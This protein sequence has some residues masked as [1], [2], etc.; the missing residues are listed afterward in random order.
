MQFRYYI[1]GVVWLSI[2]VLLFSTPLPEDHTTIFQLFPGRSVIHG[3]MF[4]GLTHIWL[5]ALKRQM[6]FEFIRKKAFL[7][8]MVMTG[9]ILVGAEIYFRQLGTSNYF[10]I[11]NIVCSILGIITGVFSFRL[12]Y[13]NCY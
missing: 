11:S 1:V 5:G 7:I 6:Y 10:G 12:L 2:M 13:R 4:W 3:I 9:L 8:V